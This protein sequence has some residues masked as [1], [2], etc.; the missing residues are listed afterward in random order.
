MSDGTM[1]RLFKALTAPPDDPNTQ[2]ELGRVARLLWLQTADTAGLDD[3][4]SVDPRHDAVEQE[5]RELGM[6]P[7]L[8]WVSVWTPAPIR[9]SQAPAELWL[10]RR[11]NPVPDG[12]QLVHAPFETLRA[13][14]GFQFRALGVVVP[15]PIT[16]AYWRIGPVPGTG[17]LF[18]QVG[19]S[20]WND[21]V[22]VSKR[23]T[24]TG[25]VESVNHFDLSKPLDETVKTRARR[26]L[27]MRVRTGR[28]PG[29][30]TYRSEAE[31]RAAIDPL[32]RALRA[33]GKHP[34]A[35]RVAENMPSQPDPKLLSRWVKR[36]IKLDWARYLDTV[37]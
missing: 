17:V 3:W 36:L 9:P 28:P 35:E 2:D 10:I 5:W 15:Y 23:M 1:A 21:V 11:R 4:V 25:L 19:M 37:V 31:L 22:E 8:E 34:S 27:T 18:E 12:G 33:S 29:S 26:A 32:V 16:S 13:A 6:P 30:G 14:E 20:V 7:W 24:S